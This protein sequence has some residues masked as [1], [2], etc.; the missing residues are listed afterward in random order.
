MLA[1]MAECSKGRQEDSRILTMSC[2]CAVKAGDK[3]TFPEMD[4]IMAD[5]LKTSNPHT[6]P[7]GRPIT[8]SLD[9]ETLFRKFNR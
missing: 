3:L 6:C 4:K 9:K 5:L 2:K 1:E 8:Y 7:H